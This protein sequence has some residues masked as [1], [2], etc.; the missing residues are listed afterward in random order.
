[1]IDQFRQMGYKSEGA[2]LTAE[3][4]VAADF[5][6]YWENPLIRP[7]NNVLER[8]PVRSTFL[9]LQPVGGSI[10]GTASGTFEPRPSGTDGTAPKWYQ[11]AAASGAVVVGDVATWGGASDASSVIGTSCTL[12]FRDGNRE[13]V[14]A[15]A[16]LSSLRFSATAG[17]RWMAE[18]EGTGRYSSAAQTALVSGV[19]P[20]AGAGLPFLGLA[21]TIGAFSGAVAEAEIS[22]EN[23]VTPQE[24]GTHAS[25]RGAN[26]ITAQALRGRF[27][28][29]LNPSVDWN[30][31]VRNDG[32]GDVL[33]VSCPMSAGAAGSVLTWA[34]SIAL[35][36]D[37][38]TEYREGIGYATVVGE[39]ISAL[40]LTQS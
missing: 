32:A 9:P 3:A 31:V 29:E 27:V 35:T 15:G 6:T 19:S 40:T 33:A 2:E 18:M 24:D 13:H 11:L 39:F 10:I 26:I 4:L 17:D 28:V 30:S 38:V 22:I 14:C 34:G 7:T 36:E 37:V 23:T 8:R 25:G 16:R 20:S 1:M 12:K 21:V 5:D